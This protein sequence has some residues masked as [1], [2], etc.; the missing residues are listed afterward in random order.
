M[1]FLLGR[2]AHNPLPAA[3]HVN[4]KKHVLNRLKYRKVVSMVRNVEHCSFAR[5]R[6]AMKNVKDRFDVYY[7]GLAAKVLP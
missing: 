1:H 7:Q 6:P 3:L 2:A 4:T 5:A